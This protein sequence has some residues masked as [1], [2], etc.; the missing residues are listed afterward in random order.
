MKFTYANIV[1]L[2]RF[3]MAPI[4]LI[5]MLSDSQIGTIIALAIFVVAALT[6]WLDGFLA[7]KYGEVT[8]HGVFLD[9]LADKVLTTSAFVALYML[10]LMQMWML[11]VI[12]LRDFGTTAMR[13]IAD[14]RGMTMKTS[15]VAKVKTFLQMVVIILAI[16]C[17][18]F[19]RSEPV[20]SLLG[21]Y[22][23]AFLASGGISVGL[24]L[25]TVL[26]I[27]SLIQY[28]IVNRRIFSRGRT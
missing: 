12:V 6:D 20:E 1:T 23:L 18:A 7:R 11:V 22:A 26:S 19:Q 3:F 25:V 10:N 27:Y 17:L 4:F 9:P 5:F 8:D 28:I 24:L 14:D 13:S 21:V 15:R 16:I 2:S